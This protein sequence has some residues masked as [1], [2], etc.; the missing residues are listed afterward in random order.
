[1][2][3][4]N[5]GKRGSGIIALIAVIAAMAVG[6]SAASAGLLRPKPAQPA[7]AEQAP[8]PV[9]AVT[10]AP[11]APVVSI[12]ASWNEQASWAE[13]ASWSEQASWAEQ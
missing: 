4:R 12:Q 3:K 9:V 10:V 1:M 7:P 11:T 2:A 5:S 8:A 13:Q 6:P